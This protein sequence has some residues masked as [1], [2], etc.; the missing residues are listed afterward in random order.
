MAELR[1]LYLWGN[2]EIKHQGGYNGVG[3]RFLWIQR[4]KQLAYQI[5]LID[6]VHSIN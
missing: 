4:L 6:K 3:M 1:P 5:L 2:R